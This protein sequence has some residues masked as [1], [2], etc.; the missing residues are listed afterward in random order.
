MNLVL[1]NKEAGQLRALCIK[2]ETKGALTPAILK[3]IYRKKWFKLFVPKKLGGLGLSLPVALKYE[4]QLAYID[5]SLGWTIT[6]C[7]GANLFSGYI[8]KNESV[9]IFNKDKVCFG[10]SG[11]ATGT[12]RQVKGGYIINGFW[13]YATGAPHLTH[14]TANC[15]IEKDGKAILNEEGTLLLR[16]FFFKKSEVTIQE[17]WNTMGLKATA[18]HSFS[19]KDLKVNIDRCFVIDPSCVT[20]AGNIYKYPFLPF[21]EATIAV[22]TLGMTRHFLDE[23]LR[24]ALQRQEQKKTD[25]AQFREIKTGIQTVLQQIKQQSGA[26]YSNINQ[27][28]KELISKGSISEECINETATLSRILVKMCRSAVTDIFPYCGLAATDETAAIN[29]IFR[30]IF[31]ASQHGLLT[32][33]SKET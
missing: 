14:F 19:V 12:A 22:N 4:E 31:T 13:K 25:K 5:G 7:A 27:S 30:D 8:E 29:R 23:A 33:A 9:K 11:A 18:G 16:S 3:I 1:K 17:D 10:G 21:A 32:F 28:W 6:L 2:A 24:I 15:I 20:L 26:L